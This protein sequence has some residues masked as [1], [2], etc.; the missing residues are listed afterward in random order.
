MRRALLLCRQSDTNEA[1]R[2]SLSLE[3]QE[4]ALRDRAASEGWAVVGVIREADIKGWY[5]E[6]DRPALIEAYRLAEQGGVD[7]LLFWSLD[8]FARSVRVQETAIHRLAKAG[9]DVVSVKESWVSQPLFRQLL[10]A[11]A[12]E[13]TRTIAAHVRRALHQRA[14]SGLPHGQAPLG[15]YRPTPGGP[16]AIKDGAEA[17]IVRR[18]FAAYDDGDSTTTIADALH[19]EGVPTPRGGGR[20]QAA[21]VG[22]ILENPAYAGRVVTSGNRTDDAHP[23]LIDPA[24]WDAVQAR[25]RHRRRPPKRK[26][27]ASFIEGHIVHACGA[28]CYLEAP[29]RRSKATFRCGS[30]APG[31]PC[32]IRPA[33]I[34]AQSAEEAVAGQLLADLSAL[35]PVRAVVSQAKDDH[36]RAS[37]NTERRAR[38]LEDRRTRAE[39]RRR[40]AE[41]LYLSNV[42][43]RA[44]FDLQEA[45]VAAELDACERELA[46]LPALP[47]PQA[48]AAMHERLQEMRV[49]LRYGAGR[50]EFGVVLRHVGRVELGPGGVRVRYK[51]EI[52]R[53]LRSH[54]VGVD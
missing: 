47:D 53:H 52:A 28:P 13:Q 15:L 46:S 27:H 44:W 37:P 41:E 19:A 34:T 29:Q 40:N 1:G 11:I 23:P 32:G 45:G 18:I 16:Y 25:R 31:P 9:V 36:R 8:R 7:V 22:W 49:T 14:R 5:D 10:G 43:D 50:T 35:R 6:A 2:D 42:R 54:G 17:D 4:R 21:A 20:W 3:S 38:E 26:G 51:L 30:R 39:Q 24:L 48:I 33:S 12:E